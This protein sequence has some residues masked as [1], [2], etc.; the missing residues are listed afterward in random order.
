MPNSM[1]A[2]FFLWYA[3]NVIVAFILVIALAGCAAMQNKRTAKTE[4]VLFKAGFQKVIADS[5]EK[6]AH[7]KTLPQKKI[8]SH[9]HEEGIRYIYADATLCQCMYV[10]D[11]DAYQSYT[12]I[13]LE[14]EVKDHEHVD[15]G[16]L[17]HEQMNWDLWGDF[18]H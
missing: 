9:Q 6:L 4:E 10:G 2:P 8:V 7:L 14:K 16:V 12:H 1:K 5:P 3:R 18:G 13:L 17:E 15:G 11:R